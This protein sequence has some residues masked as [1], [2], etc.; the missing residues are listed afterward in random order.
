MCHDAPRGMLPSTGL[1]QVP[2]GEEGGHSVGVPGG[3]PG[4]GASPQRQVTGLSGD[5]ERAALPATHL[6]HL[7]SAE[8]AGWKPRYN[9]VVNQIQRMIQHNAIN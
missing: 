6:S 7:L 9:T 3:R 5:E 4:G 8:D 2:R 1:C